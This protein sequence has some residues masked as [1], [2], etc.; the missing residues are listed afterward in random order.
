MPAETTHDLLARAVLTPRQ[1]LVFVLL[2]AGYTAQE[3]ADCL[4]CSVRTVEKH[5]EH[6]GRRLRVHSQTEIVR[7]ALLHGLVALDR[8]ALDTALP[9]SPCLPR[10]AQEGAR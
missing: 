3:C 2:A 6:L 10:A 5:R 9:E 8:P 7:L 4:C 1:L